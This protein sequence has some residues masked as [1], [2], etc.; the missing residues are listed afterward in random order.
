MQVKYFDHFDVQASFATNYFSEDHFEATVT[1]NITAL[2]VMV[3][4][5]IGIS[6]E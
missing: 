6:N 5:Y 2:L 1:V 3:T 4:L